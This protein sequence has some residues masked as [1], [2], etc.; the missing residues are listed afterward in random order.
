[1]IL[2]SALPSLI[3]SSPIVIGEQS[4]YDSDA[5]PVITPIENQVSA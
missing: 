4:D 2:Q 3:S 1:M 5:R